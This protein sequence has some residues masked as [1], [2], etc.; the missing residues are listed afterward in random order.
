MF[1]PE[2]IQETSRFRIKRTGK[3]ISGYM[4]IKKN[5]IY[6]YI[7]KIERTQELKKAFDRIR[8]SLKR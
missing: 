4:G 6:D 5:G 7:Y 2:P 8:K 3:E 1:F